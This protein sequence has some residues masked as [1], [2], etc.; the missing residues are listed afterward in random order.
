[1]TTIRTVPGRDDHLSPKVPDRLRAL[2]R[3]LIEFLR[4]YSL[5]IL[6]AALGLVLVWFGGLKVFDAS[7]VADV[8]ATAVPFLPGRA[9]VFG[10]GVLEILIGLGLVTG[11][12]MRLT[13]VLFLALMGGTFSMLLSHP[14]MAFEG[15]NPLRL[16]VVGEFIV[17]NLILVTAGLATLSTVA[18][19]H[20]DESIS[21]TLHGRARRTAPA[22]R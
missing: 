8:V 9:V 16:S 5:H 2:D 18:K 11:M 19:A 10:V 7:P 22:D 21:R 17:K 12:A 20:D 1:M 6:R 4:R 3:G 13:L 15:A 14:S